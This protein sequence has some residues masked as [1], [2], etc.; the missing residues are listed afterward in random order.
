[1]G[2]LTELH[3]TSCDEGQILIPGGMAPTSVV[4][5]RPSIL[6]GSKYNVDDGYHCLE[7]EADP[8]GLFTSPTSCPPTIA[9]AAVRP[10]G[11]LCLGKRF[12]IHPSDT[13]WRCVSHD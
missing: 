13:C 3:I 8:A 7:A 10:H 12:C 4:S 1:M 6:G 2:A 5:R 11:I 9:F